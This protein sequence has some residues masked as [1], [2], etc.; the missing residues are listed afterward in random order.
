MAARE[1][2]VEL[3]HV[4]IPRDFQKLGLCLVVCSIQEPTFASGETVY[5]L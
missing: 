2:V 3:E 4:D 5:E 1:F